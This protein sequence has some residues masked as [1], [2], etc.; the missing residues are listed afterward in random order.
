MKFLFL[1]I[2]SIPFLSHRILVEQVHGIGFRF[3][4]GCRLKRME[5]DQA[6]RNKTVRELE[7]I[8]AGTFNLHYFGHT[9]TQ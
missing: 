7:D 8:G 9:H 3:H 5:D 2:C 6:Q 4:T 1:L